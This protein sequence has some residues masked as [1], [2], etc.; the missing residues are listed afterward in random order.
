MLHGITIRPGHLLGGPFLLAADEALI[1]AALDAATAH[2]EAW[3]RATPAAA[4]VYDRQR[5]RYRPEPTAELEEFA[6]PQLLFARGFGDCDDIVIARLAELRA[7]GIDR[8][9]R[10]S[11]V[12]RESPVRAEY[13]ARI[14]RSSGVIEDPAEDL[15]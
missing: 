10:L 6:G 5:I 8:G 15:R 4:S 2:A 13:H 9:A 3:Y 1:V 14:R 7:R 12:V 11:L